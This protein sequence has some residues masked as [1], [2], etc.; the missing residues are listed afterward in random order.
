[1]L[2]KSDVQSR[3]R[4]DRDSIQAWLDRMDQNTLRP[5]RFD[6]RASSRWGY[7][8]P[9]LELELTQGADAG[10]WQQV[11][12]R[13]LSREGLG[14]LAGRFLYPRTACRVTLVDAQ[15][16]PRTVSGQ[17]VR[18]RYVV[19]SGSLYEVGI[20]L[21]RPIDVVTFTSTS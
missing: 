17:I 18:C 9:E 11:A 2:V 7:R 15:A 20:A 10:R 5:A 1:M 14:L 16:R 21:D 12:G 3:L 6:Y 19:G 4:L 8:A 13:N